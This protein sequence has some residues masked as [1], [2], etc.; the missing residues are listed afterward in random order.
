MLRGQGVKRDAQRRGVGVVPRVVRGTTEAIAAALAV[1][2]GGPVLTT[3]SMERLTA[4]LRSALAP[5]V[6]RG[7]ALAQTAEVRT[8]GMSLGGWAYHVCWSHRRLRLRA[9]KAAP[10]QW[11]ERTPA[12]AAGVTE[13]CWTMQELLR[14][15]VPLPAWVPPQR[16]GRP[17]KQKPQTGDGRGGLTDHG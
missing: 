12:M 1:T 8:A 7:R 6:R 2:G 3:A 16:R 9:R 11:Q 5:L 13:H 17:P 4:T 15:Q 10:Q 14:S